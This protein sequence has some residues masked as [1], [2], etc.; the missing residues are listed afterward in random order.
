MD[1]KQINTYQIKYGTLFFFI[2][3]KFVRTKNFET[4]FLRKSGTLE[5]CSNIKNIKT[6][7]PQPDMEKVSGSLAVLVEKSRKKA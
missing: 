4:H 6:T 3:T 2:R 5:K 7:E 1:S